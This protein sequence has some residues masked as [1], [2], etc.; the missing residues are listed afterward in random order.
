MAEKIYS[1]RHE[2]KFLDGLGTH[3]PTKN[4]NRNKLLWGYYKGA[5]RRENWSDIDKTE[6]LLRVESELGIK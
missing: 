2:H 6:I 4:K 3:G 1:T 5:K